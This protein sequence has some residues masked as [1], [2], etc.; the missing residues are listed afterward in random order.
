MLILTFH[1][2][3]KQSGHGTKESGCDNRYR[4]EDLVELHTQIMSSLLQKVLAQRALTDDIRA[5]LV[6]LNE[7]HTFQRSEDSG[8]LSELSE[9]I[10]ISSHHDHDDG[11]ISSRSLEAGFENAT[12]LTEAVRTQLHLFITQVASMYKNNA[13]HNFEHASHVALGAYELLR[14]LVAQENATA[15]ATLDKGR[16]G[17]SV[18]PWRNLPF[19]LSQSTNALASDAL[20]Q[21]AVVFS[22]LLHDVEHEGVPN[23]QLAKEKPEIAE[24]Y[25][26]KS[27]AEQNS[28]HIGWDLLGKDCFRD[29]R[30]CIFPTGNDRLRFRKMYENVVM[31]TDICDPS[32]QSFQKKK[33]DKDFSDLE[34]YEER[35][36]RAT[37]A[38]DLF[39]Q[40]SD[41]SHTMVSFFR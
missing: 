33:I 23:T 24:R 2:L 40:V 27:L 37:V 35:N 29:L 1:S 8:A 12:A 31:A 15:N 28:V 5:G 7:C 3:S 13:F 14:R 19:D 17:C 36:R 41:I 22:A 30:A 38:M 11:S 20:A 9:M 32:L 34:E 4:T 16:E 39:I 6:D 21:F 25:Q 18:S 10:Q 26:H